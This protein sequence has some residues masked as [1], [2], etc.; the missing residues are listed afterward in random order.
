VDFALAGFLDRQLP[1]IFSPSSRAI[2]GTHP[3][4]I[5][6]YI[7]YFHG[8]LEERYIYIGKSRNKNTGMRRIN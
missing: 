2:R 5:T 8:Y 7:E 3:S 1:S 6:K 4:N